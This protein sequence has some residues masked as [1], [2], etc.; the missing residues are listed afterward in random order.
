MKIN[1]KKELQ[2]IAI[3]DFADIDYKDFVMV[4]KECTKDPYFLTIDTE[5]PASDP[6]RFKNNLFHFFKN[7]SN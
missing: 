3:N 2:S 6:L 7:N 1:N 5:L 4:Y